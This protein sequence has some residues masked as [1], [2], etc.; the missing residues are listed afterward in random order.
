MGR[1]ARFWSRWVFD[2]TYLP[3]KWKKKNHPHKSHKVLARS[4]C[5][6]LGSIVPVGLTFLRTGFAWQLDNGGK[7]GWVFWVVVVVILAI[8]IISVIAAAAT[9]QKSLV[10][11]ML[12]GTAGSANLTLVL[13]VIQKVN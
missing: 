2:R 4:G 8:W 7:V 12:A 10:N 11:Y 13:L 9:E 3:V 6:F 5:A 1:L